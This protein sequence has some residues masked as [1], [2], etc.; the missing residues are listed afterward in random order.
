MIT[1]MTGFGSETFQL[2]GITYS[3]EIKTLNSKG[4][5]FV[6]KASTI[7]RNLEIDTKNLI[8]KNLERGKIELAIYTKDSRKGSMTIDEQNFVQQYEFLN[9]L[10]KSVGSTVDVFPIALD[11]YTSMS[12]GIDFNDDELKLFY[13]S[14]ES[15]CEQTSRFR[16]IEGA[17]TAADLENWLDVIT[18]SLDKIL[19]IDPNRAEAKRQKILTNIKDL[20]SEADID[21]NRLH[22]E[23]VFYIEKYDISEEVSRLRQHL[24]LFRVTMSEV[25]NCG[26]KLG[27]IAQEMGREINTIGSKANDADMQG[28]V[29]EMKDYLERIKEQ[30]NNIL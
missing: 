1:S 29:V 25:E 27:F 13:N 30:L 23:M 9:Q 17:K 11:K 21:Y 14:V 26:K 2:R 3:I 8:Q 6:L 12:D 16:K 7:F 19:T 10:A 18:F 28:L 15:V 5:E 4:F 22:Q 20:V 24:Q